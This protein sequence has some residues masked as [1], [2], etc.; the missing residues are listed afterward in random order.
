MTRKL[1]VYRTWN[2]HNIAAKRDLDRQ[3][4][5]LLLKEDSL[6]PRIRIDSLLN[7]QNQ[8][9]L[10]SDSFGIAEVTYHLGQEHLSLG[11]LMLLLSIFYYAVNSVVNSIT[12]RH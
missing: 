6:L 2:K 10:I 7:L 11:N 9:A 4:T 12:I 5:H 3:V 1:A 8:Y